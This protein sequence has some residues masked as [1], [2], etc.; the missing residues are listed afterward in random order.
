M[1][2]ALLYVQHLLGIGHLVRAGALARGLESAGIRT[3]LVS[4]GMPVP[5][6]KL[7]RLEQ[8]PPVRA[9]DESFTALVD[10]NGNIVDEAWRAKRRARLLAIYDRVRP[11]ILITELFP[12]G[13]RQM[14]FELDA[15]LQ[16]ARM[17]GVSGKVPLIVSSVRDILVPSTKAGREIEIVSYVRQHYD[18]V[19]V[20]GDENLIPFARSFPCAAEIAD[21]TRSTGYVTDP[22][23]VRQGAGSPGFDEVVVSAGGGAVTGGLIDTAVEARK[24]SKLRGKRWRVLVGYNYP[25][26]DFRYRQAKA[27]PG[28]I[29]ERAREDFV[30]LLANCA[31]SISQGG[32]NTVTEILATGARAVCIPFSTGRESEQSL[33]CRLLADRGMLQYIDEPTLSAERL[34][35]AV[36]RALEIKSADHPAVAMDG[37][38]QSAALLLQAMDSRRA[39]SAD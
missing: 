31:L 22:A 30:Q 8:L 36:D 38:A 14:S 23:P 2:T 4:G 35:S 15:L 13:R 6:R 33:R 39:R 28:I 17:D 21:L 16:H 9:A 37:A 24:L 20:H 19:L 26:E 1:V 3:I 25:E 29:V 32:Y 18:L 11:N 27:P 5:V 7:P 12:F 10:E 34:A